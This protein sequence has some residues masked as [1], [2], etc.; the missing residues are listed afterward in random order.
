ML[1]NDL[2]SSVDIRPVRYQFA[3]APGDSY[4]DNWLVVA[5]TVMTPEGSW[6]FADPCLL[7]DEARQVSAWLRAVAAETVDVTEPDAEGEL[8]PDTWFIEPVVA[9]SIADRIDGGT[10]VIRVHLSL[11]AAPPWQ[12]GDDGADIHQY[13]VEVRL[14]APALLHAADQWDLSLASFPRR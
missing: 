5:G 9:F 8:S 10:T 7:T 1:L 13:V 3:T 6:S 11:E 2:S 4:D 14:D 12:Q